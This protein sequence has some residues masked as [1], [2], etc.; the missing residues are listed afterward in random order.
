MKTTIFLS[1]KMLKSSAI[2]RDVA[3]TELICPIGIHPESR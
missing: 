3:K 1:Y 2:E